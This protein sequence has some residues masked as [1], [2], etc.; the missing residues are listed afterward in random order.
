M[1][2]FTLAEGIL[3][4]L[5]EV[6][7]TLVS[8]GRIHA[9]TDTFWMR[10]VDT[11]NV[12]MVEIALAPEAF[13]EYNPDNEEL[14]IDFG[15]LKNALVGIEKGCTL[16][17]ALL[18]KRKLAF[19]NDTCTYSFTLLD[20]NT[21]RKDANPPVV[22]LPAKV[23]VDGAEFNAMIKGCR[24]VGDKVLLKADPG[25]GALHLQTEG[26]ADE[27]AYALACEPSAE[28]HS[29][30]DLEYLKKMAKV[31]AKHGNVD[32][33]FGINHPLSLSFCPADGLCT[34]TYLLAPRIE[35]D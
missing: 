13:G 14:G 9:D 31:A 24:A 23:R 21:I 29:L 5:V 4:D 28:A 34:A 25:A 15:K 2:Y 3:R 6:A 10:A 33:A 30:Y 32:L 26:D 18:E 16:K 27:I 20:P 19:G 1:A 7:T 12:A 35:A 8:E 11:A 22:E 17:V